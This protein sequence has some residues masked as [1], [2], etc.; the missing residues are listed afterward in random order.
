MF[1]AAQQWLFESIFQPVMLWLDMGNYV[2][3]GYIAADWFLWGCVQIALIAVVL[4]PLQRLRDR[5]STRL[6][7]SHT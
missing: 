4:V 1:D 6:N 7:S 2:E 3:D 5:K